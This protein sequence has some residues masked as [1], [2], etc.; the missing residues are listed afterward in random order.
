MREHEQVK[1]FAVDDIIQ[2]VRKTDLSNINTFLVLNGGTGVGKTTAIMNNVLEELDHKF[3]RLQTMLVV[4]SRSITVEQLRH[5]YGEADVCQRLGFANMIKKG[6]VDYDWVVIDE[7]HGLFSEA[8]FAEDTTIIGDWIKHSRK[9]THIIFITANDEYFEELSK[10]FFSEDSS[11]IYLFPDFTKYVSNTYVKEI[12]FVK[13]KN[14]NATLDYFLEQQEGKRGIVFLKSA[15]KVKDWYFKLLDQKKG[16]AMLV[17]R[18]NQTALSLDIVQAQ[19]AAKNLMIELSD[20]Q[21]GLTLADLQDMA[22]KQR[23][24]DGKE[25]LFEALRNEHLPDDISIL[26]VTDTLQEGMSLT[27]P[28]IDFMIIDGYGEVEIR[29]KVGRFRGNLD[30]LYI[31]FNPS[32]ARR[33]FQ[34][35]SDMFA[36]F[37]KLQAEGNQ[38]ELAKQFGL[39][40]GARFKV[41]YITERLHED[42]AKTYEVNEQAYLHLLRDHKD[43]LHL[44]NNTEDAVIEMYS[45][46]GATPK[47]VDPNVIRMSNQKELLMEIAERWRGIPLKGPAQEAL[48]QDF[49]AVGIKDKSRHPITSLRGCTTLFADAGIV[50][51]EK[52]ATV[53]DIQQWPQY[54]VKV[55]EKY[56][57]IV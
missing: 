31:I 13:T 44:M 50:V 16:V 38:V 11:F 15:S 53:K 2:L 52:Q 37:R 43:Y 23:V 40:K 49:A 35:Q 28:K 34:I 21:S 26:I 45:Y 51:A 57:V 4:E 36:H 8:S 1:E 24:A 55:R 17:S 12:Q 18:A 41:K 33:D 32:N 39:L 20:G 7:C 48:L 19:S 29:Q 46:L 9:N 54:L 5:K 56:R 27:F 47:L 14:T 22:D 30:Q 42:G 25:S 6:K 3:G 10:Q